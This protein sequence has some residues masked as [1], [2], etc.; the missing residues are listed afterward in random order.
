MLL[1]T[2]KSRSRALVEARRLIEDA[3]AILHRV[4]R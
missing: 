1:E 2:V 3:K 4:G